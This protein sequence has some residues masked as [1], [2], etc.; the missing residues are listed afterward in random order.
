VGKTFSGNGKLKSSLLSDLPQSPSFGRHFTNQFLSSLHQVFSF[1]WFWASLL[2]FTWVVNVYRDPVRIRRLLL[3]I[4][5]VGLAVAMLAV[6]QNVT[7]NELVYGIVPAM[8]PNSG[9]FMNH[10]HFSQFMNL[11]IG[12]GAGTPL[13]TLDRCFPATIDQSPAR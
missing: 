10:S 13:G 9:P 8:H 3:T 4:A 5:C 1:G 6:Y 11:S 2:I 12:C 7:G